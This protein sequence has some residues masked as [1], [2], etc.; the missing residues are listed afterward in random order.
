MACEG[1]CKTKGMAVLPVRYAVVPETISGALPDWAND[2]KITSVPLANKEHYA[3][4][5]LR[6]GYL[7]VFYEKGAAGTQY[8]QCYSVAENGSLWLQSVPTNPL[9]VKEP[10]CRSGEHVKQ[11]V[12]FM[13]IEMPEKCNAVWFAFS[14][15]PWSQ[16]TL[17]RYK[18]DSK[19][20]AGRMQKVNPQKWIASHTSPVGTAVSESTLEDVL[21]YQLHSASGLLPNPD[22][23]TQTTLSRAE[24][25]WDPT[26]EDNWRVNFDVLRQQSSLY[27]WAAE[28]SGGAVFTENAMTAR[29]M[30]SPGLILP[31]WDA[32]GIT[33][34][35]N[36]WCQ[37][38]LG[39]QAQFLRERELELWTKA[40]LDA[41]KGALSEKT[42]A[43]S[44]AVIERMAQPDNSSLSHEFLDNRM[45]NMEKLY[46]DKPDVLA[47]VKADDTLVRSWR[48]Q[49]VSAFYPDALL[50]SPPEPLAVH[51]RRV[52]EIK[53]QVDQEL[54]ARP[55]NLTDANLRSWSPYQA[56]LN[57]NRQKNFDAVYNAVVTEVNSLFQKRMLSVLNWLDSPLL[58]A[59]LDDFH[60][61]EVRA[62]VFYQ[63][64]VT[65]AVNGINSCPAGAA[66]IDGWWNEYSTKRKEN[67]LWRHVTGNNPD[68]MDELEPLLA[69]TKAKKDDPVTPSNAATVTAML[70]QQVG[71]LKKMGGYY[72]KSLGIVNKGLRENASRIEATIFSSDAFIATVGDRV[73]RLLKVDAMGEKLATTTFRLVFMVRAGI[74]AEKVN[75]LVDE[76]LKDAPE[77]RNSV[78][79][80][81]RGSKRFMATGEEITR[82]KQEMWG[83][84]DEHF[85]TEQGQKELRLARINSLLLVMNA[86]D[87]IYLCGEV[88][89]DKKPLASLIA[90]GLAMVGQTTTVLLPAVE[91]G[92]EARPFTVA[93]FKGVGSAAGGAASLMSVYA[94]GMATFS[95]FK[96]NRFFLG[97]VLVVKT[98]VDSLGALKSIGLLL[99]LIGKSLAKDVSTKI[100]RFLTAEFFGVRVLAVLMTWEAMLAITLLQSLIIWASDN[101]LQVWCKQSVFGQTP[102]KR[103]KPEQNKS[104]EAAIKEIA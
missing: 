79:A 63:S 16:E 102:R 31:L 67:L 69:S 29:G 71:S 11:N 20:R 57:E 49:N 66:K 13:C 38:V 88:K 39:K 83:R 15:Y 52:A 62:G 85:A 45:K 65:M 37:D 17:E 24:S 26:V 98:L 82:V 35:L 23:G 103:T 5:V 58:I 80:G 40:N 76:Y 1:R 22:S 28:R 92:L 70:M 68:L 55:Q 72:Q 43:N 9:P 32:V 21:D 36:G 59:T 94:D 42:Q 12:E 86:I 73:S 91:K 99:E 41:I 84:L 64:A 47:Q 56:C 77:L 33:H 46:R 74:P 25:L 60:C 87:F 78:L 75:T 7:Y 2:P 18:T 44:E 27:Q 6:Q 97:A 34:E 61:H 8:W 19:F 104:L 48:A 14:Q 10:D 50:Q 95:E 90:S 51:Q 101:D 93:W 100:T 4:R 96:N 54:T 53:A 30:G 3:L 89:D 81:I